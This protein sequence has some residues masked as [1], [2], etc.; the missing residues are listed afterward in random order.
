MANEIDEP[1]GTFV[2]A[3]SSV[4]HTPGPWEIG[5]G[6]GRERPLEVHTSPESH[7][8]LTGIYVLPICKEIT[9]PDKEANARLIAAAP[10]LLAIAK[11][12]LESE[13]VET[14]STLAIVARAAIAKAEG[15]A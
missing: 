15:R 7:G 4:S 5:N 6:T 3:E 10:E 1:I 14:Y 8:A 12:V 2:V 13:Q 9:G 11:A